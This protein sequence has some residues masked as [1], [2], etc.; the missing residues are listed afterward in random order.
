MTVTADN[1]WPPDANAKSA[2]E[3]HSIWRENV[4]SGW[5]AIY[6]DLLQKIV[7]IEPGF[8]VFQAGEKRG[9]LRVSVR[10]P[11]ADNLIIAKLLMDARDRSYKTCAECGGPGRLCVDGS[12]D[13]IT[14]C[15]RHDE[16][17]WPYVPRQLD[18]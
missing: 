9:G 18:R 15:D 5:R 4:P 3:N 2:A 12:F 7:R 13:R 11:A 1:T 17:Y 16:G 14:L 6:D 10:G 8:R